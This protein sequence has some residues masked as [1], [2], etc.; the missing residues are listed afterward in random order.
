MNQP[1]VAMTWEALTSSFAP[2]PPRAPDLMLRGRAVGA[3]G[4]A[5]MAIVNR[6]TDSFY[7]PARYADDAAAMDAVARAVADGAEIVDVGGVRAGVGPEVGTV[8]E[9][10]RV[11]PFVA[12]VRAEH[13]DLIVSVDTWRAEVAREVAAAGAD[14]INDT[15]AG[16]DPHLVEVA[17]EHGLGVVCSHTGGAAPR[18]DPV[19]VRFSLPH[20]APADAD[21]LDAVVADVV[22]ALSAGARRAITCGVPDRSVLV[23]PTHDFGKRTVDSL[24][25]VRRTAALVALGYPVLM[26]LSRKDFVGETLDLPVDERLEGTLAATALA[27]WQGARVFRTHDVRATRRVLDMVAAVRGELPPHAPV[28]GL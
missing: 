23:D 20:D 24:Q 14:L 4:G 17:G 21:P 5:V 11:A 1:A 13:P 16:A 22:A 27:A 10:E 9:I 8:E 18:T 25:L 26:A 3:A 28:R 2:V 19:D 15:W 7:A 12:R 6:T